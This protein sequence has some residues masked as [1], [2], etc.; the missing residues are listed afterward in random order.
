MEINVRKHSKNCSKPLFCNYESKREVLPIFADYTFCFA[1]KS[2]AYSLQP[3]W[4]GHC[5][6][7]MSI[8]VSCF[9]YLYDKGL[10]M[11]SIQHCS[12]TASST[13]DVSCWSNPD[14]PSYCANTNMSS[15]ISSM[16]YGAVLHVNT[17]TA[18]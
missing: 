3:T 6:V 11:K 18:R 1:S 8:W 5:L 16:F 2:R 7:R 12:I 14:V 17:V 10:N 13:S 9:S 15:Q 4:I